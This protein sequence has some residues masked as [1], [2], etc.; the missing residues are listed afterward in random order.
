M[1]A[2]TTL[3]KFPRKEGEIV[4]ATL[5]HLQTFPKN[6]RHFTI[7][8]PPGAPGTHRNRPSKHGAHLAQRPPLTVATRSLPRLHLIIGLF[9]VLHIHREPDDELGPLAG[10]FTDR[11]QG[12]LVGNDIIGAG[13]EA[14]T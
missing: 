1:N 9:P 13:M 11:L 14:E 10:T 7:I 12:S 2:Q 8:Q 5:H 6:T 4:N 3:C